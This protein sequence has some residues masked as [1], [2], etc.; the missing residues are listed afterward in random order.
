MS[1]VGEKDGDEESGWAR[2]RTSMK[3]GFVSQGKKFL[4]YAESMRSQ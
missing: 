2:R 1:V 3:H 4:I